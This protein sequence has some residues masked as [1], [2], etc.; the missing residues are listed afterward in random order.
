MN[1]HGKPET[2][3]IEPVLQ[4]IDVRDGMKVLDFACEAI[5]FG[6]IGFFRALISKKEY[7]SAFKNLH[8]KREE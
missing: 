6:G 7:Q 4:T 1:K 8:I 2:A 3:F 5:L